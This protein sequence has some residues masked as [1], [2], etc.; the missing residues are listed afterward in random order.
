FYNALTYFPNRSLLFIVQVLLGSSGAG[1][2]SVTMQ[3]AEPVNSMSGAL[4]IVAYPRLASSSGR[5]R[6]ASQFLQVAAIMSIL[7]SGTLMALAL[8][9]L[10][11]IFGVE[12]QAAIYPL[13]LLLVAF[14]ILSGR[15]I[16][17]LW[18]VHEHKSYAVPIRAAAAALIVTLAAGIVLVIR[19]GTVGAA[20]AT[21]AGSATLMTIL[22]I[23]LQKRGFVPRS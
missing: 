6:E 21:M 8:V 10:V 2:Y 7:G 13:P 19:F 23:G 22:L 18:Y 3:L 12:Y 16:A 5:P 1:I 17:A 11:P 4:A 20:C 14:V 15:E 9:L